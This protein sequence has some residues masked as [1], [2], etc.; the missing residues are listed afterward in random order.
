MLP[1]KSRDVNSSLFLF[2]RD[3]MMVSYVPL[4]NQSVILLSSQHN[5]QAVSTAEH[6]KPDII[7]NYSKSKC[8]VDGADKFALSV[9]G[10][11]STIQFAD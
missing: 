8:A 10:S 7:L 1:F 3:A 5:D 2:S 6:A 9:I 4:K 11:A